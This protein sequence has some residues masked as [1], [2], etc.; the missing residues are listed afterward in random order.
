MRTAILASLAVLLLASH[1]PRRAAAEGTP[2]TTTAAVGSKAPDFT[3]TD[4]LGKEQKLSSYAGKT[5]VLEWTNYDC[6]FVKKQY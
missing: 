6:P 5:V 2:D 4:S 3:V 1:A